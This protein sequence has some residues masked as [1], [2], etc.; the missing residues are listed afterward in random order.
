MVNQRISP[1]ELQAER[2]E[3][4]P[5]I[6]IDVRGEDEFRAGHIP[7]AIHV[8][9]ADLEQFLVQLPKDRPIVPY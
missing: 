2:T 9:A 1:Q 6:V 3:Q 4:T 5:P 8:P 7:G